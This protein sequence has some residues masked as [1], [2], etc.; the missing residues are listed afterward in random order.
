MSRDD[1]VLVVEITDPQVRLTFREICEQGECHAEMVLKMVSHGIIE[2][3][4]PVQ[5]AQIASWRFDLAALMR[6]RKAVRLERDLKMN[7]PGLAMSLDLL[8]EVDAM[9]REIAA[10]RHQLRHLSG[11]HDSN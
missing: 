6:L 2:P 5:G 9:R 3:V 7:L 4:G 10:L 1:E 8:D 11:E